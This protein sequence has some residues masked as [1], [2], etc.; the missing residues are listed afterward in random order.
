MEIVMLN[1]KQ[2]IVSKIDQ[3]LRR[4]YGDP[5]FRVT[6][7]IWGTYTHGAKK[8]QTDPK[9]HATVTLNGES[10]KDC[11]NKL[12]VGK[13]EYS[14]EAKKQVLTGGCNDILYKPKEVIDLN[15]EYSRAFEELQAQMK[16]QRVSDREREV[17]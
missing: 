15:P 2:K 10:Y 13:K 8:G 9:A 7:D 16:V 11:K 12:V 5:S 3:N 14:D 6:F 4:K 17:A 1:G